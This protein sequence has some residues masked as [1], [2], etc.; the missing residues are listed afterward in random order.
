MR[1]LKA[2]L[3][4]ETDLLISPLPIDEC[5]GRLRAAVIGDGSAAFGQEGVIGKVG[6]NSLRVRK[7]LRMGMHNSFQTYLRATLE[8][9]GTSTRLTC[10]FGLHRFVA[11][12]MLFWFGLVL[13]FAV[14]FMV[15]GLRSIEAVDVPG[16][17]FVV[18]LMMVPMGVG[19][20]GVCRRMAR[21]ERQF[22]LDFLRETIDARELSTVGSASREPVVRR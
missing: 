19:L 12:F 9:E 10:H 16:V 20:V 1:R 6:E 22:L 17:A 13:I 4:Y 14:G 21:G 11:V 15:V 8:S 18:P 7:G 5:V 3:G 2:W